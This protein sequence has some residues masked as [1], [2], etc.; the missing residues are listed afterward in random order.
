MNRTVS[1]WVS[2]FIFLFFTILPA[3]VSYYSDKV[4]FSTV[5]YTSP[6]QALKK[7]SEP[8]S[9][10]QMFEDHLAIRLHRFPAICENI[11]IIYGSRDSS[12]SPG[13]V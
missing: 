7:L 9:I 10:G 11:S 2:Q 12:I 6:V 1:L 8:Q 3:L 4:A 5:F 13:T